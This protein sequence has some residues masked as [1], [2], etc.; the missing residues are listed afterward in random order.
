MMTGGLGEENGGWRW[1]S[2]VVRQGAGRLETVWY[3][4]RMEG[5]GWERD[6][7]RL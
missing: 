3:R 5:N 1:Y 4:M 7:N 6:G 2:T